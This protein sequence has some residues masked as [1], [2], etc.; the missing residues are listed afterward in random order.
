L[1]P[2]ALEAME[3]WGGAADPSR[4]HTEGRMARAALENSRAQ[5]AGLFQVRPRQVVLTSGATEAISSAVHGVVATRPGRVLFSGVEHSAVTASSS[6]HPHAV[7]PVDSAGRNDVEALERELSTGDVTLVHCQW[8]N[9]EVG[10]RQPVESVI[11]VSH[12]AGA[13]VHVDA[14]A[15]V[16]HDPVALGGADLLSFS[17]HKFGAPAGTGGLVLASGLRIDSLLRGGAQE[18]GRRA[19]MENVA[20]AVGLGAVAEVLSRCR[21]GEA[22][23]A[24]Q[25]IDELARLCLAVEGVTRYGDPIDCLPHLLCLGVAGVEAEGVLIGLDQAGVAAHSGSS[26][27]SEDLEPSPVLEAM[28][29][30]AEHSLRLSVGWNTTDADVGAAGA[31]FASAVSRLRTLAG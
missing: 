8:A 11:E 10:T 4:V 29:V 20:A 9:H 3:Q 25:Q 1:R 12:A 19:G 13:L 24:R 16:G 15:A 2:E 27:S 28:G 14:S 22:K 5:V 7:L 17:G 23:R 6:V 26:C 30:D 21:E 31:A 18:R